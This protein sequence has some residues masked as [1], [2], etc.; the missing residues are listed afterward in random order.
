MSSADASSSVHSLSM[1]DTTVAV[2][3]SSAESGNALRATPLLVSATSPQ[4]VDISSSPENLPYGLRGRAISRDSR[5]HPGTPP[6]IRSTTASSRSLPGTPQL[7]APPAILVASPQ[8]NND[9]M[10]ADSVGDDFIQF[11]QM[12]QQDN[13]VNTNVLVVNCHNDKRNLFGTTKYTNDEHT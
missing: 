5:V 9:P 13:Y 10:A 6:R 1:S 8:A 4:I 2:T 11:F 12:L 3:S 7:A